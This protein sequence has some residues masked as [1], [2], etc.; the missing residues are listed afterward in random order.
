[1]LYSYS[2]RNTLYYY[3]PFTFLEF[4]IPITRDLGSSGPIYYFQLVF[5]V[6]FLVGVCMASLL[7]KTSTK[8]LPCIGGS[9]LVETRTYLKVY[10]KQ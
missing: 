5:L 9:V 7:S 6:I 1:M 10:N 3:C 8:Y 4:E 2:Y